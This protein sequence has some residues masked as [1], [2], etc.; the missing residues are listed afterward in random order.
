[1]NTLDQARAYYGG[2]KDKA[3][4]EASRSLRSSLGIDVRIRRVG[5]SAH[6]QVRDHWMRAGRHADAGWDW[7]EIFRRHREPKC[8]DLAIWSPDSSSLIALALATMTMEAATLRYCEGNPQDGCD[9]KGKRVLIA[10]EAVANYA[11]GAG[12]SEIRIDPVNEKLAS[13]YQTVYGFE[14][15]APK[16]GPA[17]YRKGI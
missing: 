16:K 12:L 17:Y 3:C 1:V 8:L 6:E 13:L 7:E 2:L 9:Y 11:L 14:L 10:L 15:V 4:L 5:R